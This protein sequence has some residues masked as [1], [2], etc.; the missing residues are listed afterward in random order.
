MAKFLDYFQFVQDF[1]PNY[2]Q[3]NDP[4]P[5]NKFSLYEISFSFFS[6]L[7][8]REQMLVCAV[9]N[10]EEVN[11][12]LSNMQGTVYALAEGVFPALPVPTWASAIFSQTIYETALLDFIGNIVNLP[13]FKIEISN[14]FTFDDPIRDILDGPSFESPYPLGGG[15]S[16]DFSLIDI[17]NQQYANFLLARILKFY[18]NPSNNAVLNTV[19]RVTQRPVSDVSLSKSGNT[20][21]ITVNNIPDSD[22]ELIKGFIEFRDNYNEPLYM[23]PSYGFL[24]FFLNYV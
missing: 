20:V 7:Y 1:L 2:W 3:E 24:E 23:E 14:I 17:T 4:L 13:R 8:Y 18:G 19:A 16:A 10:E 15:S 22:F 5:A 11:Y 21:T 6:Y 9:Q 12:G